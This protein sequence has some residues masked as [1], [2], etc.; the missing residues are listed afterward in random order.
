MNRKAALIFLSVIVAVVAYTVL[1]RWDAKPP[2][3]M[4]AHD[5]PSSTN[6]DPAAVGGFGA[7]PPASIVTHDD[8]SST[9]GDAAVTGKPPE[10]ITA[11]GRNRGWAE[12]K[13]FDEAVRVTGI[14]RKQLSVVWTSRD[15]DGWYVLIDF[16]TNQ[17]GA[18]CSVLVQDDGTAEFHGG[19]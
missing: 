4:V 3:P 5:D 1:R 19:L 11:N 10:G 18:H 9:N 13:A 16:G 6:G 7:N 14:P 12:A 15:A 17:P 2:A 8:S